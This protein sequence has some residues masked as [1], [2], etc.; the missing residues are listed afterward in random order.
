MEWVT[1]IA[2]LIIGGTI[3]TVGICLLI[4]GAEESKSK[5]DTNRE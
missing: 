5:D 3:A 1:F 4:A 2:G